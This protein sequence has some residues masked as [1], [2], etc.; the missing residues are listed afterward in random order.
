MIPRSSVAADRIVGVLDTE[1]SVRPPESPVT[2]L[3]QA[4]TIEFRISF[5]Y[6]GRSSS[7]RRVVLV[8]A[9]RPPPSSGARAPARRRSSTSSRA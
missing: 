2:D 1:S 6:P 4:G 9:W 5:A 3:P 7:A 8:E